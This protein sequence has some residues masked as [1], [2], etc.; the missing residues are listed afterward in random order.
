MS[1]YM[2]VLITLVWEL[3]PSASLCCICRKV[4]NCGV[5]HPKNPSGEKLL[6]AP[7]FY[8]PEFHR[9]AFSHPTNRP[10]LSS[11][12][13]ALQKEEVQKEI[14]LSPALHTTTFCALSSTITQD[15][16][17]HIIFIDHPVGNPTP[18]FFPTPIANIVILSSNSVILSSNDWID[19]I[20][21]I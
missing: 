2:R 19:R 12:R 16:D 20:P 7:C 1:Q 6:Y 4:F 18:I 13:E 21:Q 14:L 17:L 15:L 9:A 3:H 10:S 8:S 11:S 5:V